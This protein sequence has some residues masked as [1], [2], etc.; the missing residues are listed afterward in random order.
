VNIIMRN[1]ILKVISLVLAVTLWLFVKS[2]SGGE[3]EL[4]APL[5]FF[6]VPTNLIVTQVSEDAINV[7]ISGPLSPLEGVPSQDAR[8]RIDLSRARPGVNT[9]DILPDNFTIPLGSKITQISPSS[10]KVELDRVTEKIVPVKAAV[11][12]RPARGY[13]IV[14]ITVD[15]PYI[16]LWGANSQLVNL[17]E[18]QTEE[19]DISGLREPVVLEVS[20]RL[21]DLRLKEGA[22]GAVKVAV[23]VKEE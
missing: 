9:F 21:G 16:N 14:K 23:T 12:G 15:P 19:V 2:K 1:P 20:L 13:R 22:P 4:V 7:R 11:R 3:V 5:E 8:A 10:V 6:R 18:V 17:R